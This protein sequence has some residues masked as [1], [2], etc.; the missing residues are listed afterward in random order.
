MFGARFLTESISV[1]ISQVVV[2]LHL[3]F[4]VLGYRGNKHRC[5]VN[6]MTPLNCLPSKT[7]YLVL[8]CRH[9]P[10]LSGDVAERSHFF[11]FLNTPKNVGKVLIYL[12]KFISNIRPNYEH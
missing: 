5:E 7:P 10:L 11:L 3:E 6:S 9:Y 2:N 12:H 1:Y 4:P 8:E